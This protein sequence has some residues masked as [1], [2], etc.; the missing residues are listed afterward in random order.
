M[1]KMALL[2][3][4]AAIE[5]VEEPLSDLHFEHI[6]K[7]VLQKNMFLINNPWLGLEKLS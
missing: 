2:D 5:G 3:L 1:E 6:L 7:F 4:L